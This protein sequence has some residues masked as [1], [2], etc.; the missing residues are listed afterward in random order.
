MNNRPIGVFDS[1]VGGVS[2]LR[3]LV[4]IMPNEHYIYLGDTVNAP[5]GVRTQP[6]IC[7]LTRRA[8]DVLM[9]KHIKAL[10]I[11][12]NTATSAAAETLRA[13][14]PIPVVG[15]EPALKPAAIEHTSGRIAV[16]ATPATLN[17]PKFQNLW[18]QYGEHAE[19]IPCAGLMEFVERGDLNSDAVKEYLMKKLDPGDGEPFTAIVLGCTHYVFLRRTIRE[20]KPNAKRYDGN[21][22]TAQRLRA[23]LER[24]GVLGGGHGSVTLQTTGDEA[25]M[26]PLMKWLFNEPIEQ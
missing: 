19:A 23:L 9:A 20:L 2:V 11:A 14:L 10:L 5:Y 26:L 1:S 17:L 16:L 25:S 6:E 24:E 21:L 8:A 12:C 18:A 7:E 22:G 4:R 15:M 13:Q 3:E